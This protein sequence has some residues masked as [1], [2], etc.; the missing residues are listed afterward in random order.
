M[1]ATRTFT[2]VWEV[3]QRLVSFGVTRQELIKVVAGVVAA[4]ADAVDNDPVTAEGLFAYIFGTRF[5]RSLF[6]S[7]GYLTYRKDNIEGVEHAER[8]LKI[9]YQNVDVAASIQQTPRALSAKG[10]ASDRVIESG[11]GDLFTEEELA[12]A[13]VVKFGK[14]ETGVW[15]F[16]VSVSG[17]DV[18][19]ELSLPMRIEGGN[20]ADFIER[21]FI[22]RGGEWAGLI[23]QSEPDQG[24]AE[25]EPVVTRK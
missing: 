4:R 20:F 8:D 2:E 18:R 16:C 22:V 19:A 5:L 15:Y 12:S 10:S 13:H 3:D 9:I 21:I 14:I 24:P 17:D 1:L 11:Q 7:K 6:R 25:F 23:V